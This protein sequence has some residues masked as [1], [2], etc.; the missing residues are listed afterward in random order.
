MPGAAAILTLAAGCVL[1]PA[2]SAYYVS[3][4]KSKGPDVVFNLTIPANSAFFNYRGNWSEGVGA[5]GPTTIYS[6]ANMSFYAA[7]TAAY[8]YAHV[9]DTG[10]PEA[11]V[12]QQPMSLLANTRYNGTNLGDGRWQYQYGPTSEMLFTFALLDLVDRPVMLDSVTI[13]TGMFN[14]A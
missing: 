12:Q 13:Q 11:E 5:D 8:V 4:F 9:N 10:V 14:E 3:P 2:A 6:G 7:G 1:A